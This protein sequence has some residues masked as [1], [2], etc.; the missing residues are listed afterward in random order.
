KDV[1]GAFFW[2]VTTLAYVRHVRMSSLPG[3]KFQI[4]NFKSWGWYSLA[5][6]CFILGLMSKP[7]LVPLPF[8]LLLLDYWPLQRLRMT[9]A[10]GP[11][12]SARI[13]RL[14]SLLLEKVPFFLAAVSVAVLAVLTQNAARAVSEGVPL[15]ARAGNALVSCC[16]Y[17]G[18]LFYPAH[19]ACFYPHPGYW[20]ASAVVLSGIVLAAVLVMA[21]ANRR[22]H[23]WLLTGWLWFL[24]TLAPAAGWVQV[25]E[26]SMADRFTYIP[27]LGLIWIL[28]WGVRQVSLRWH[29]PKP[30]LAVAAVAA[31]AACAVC[32]RRQIGCWKDSE[33]LFQHALAVTADNHVARFCLGVAYDE[34]GRPDDAI[35]QY[36]TAITLK[37]DYPAAHINL[38]FALANTG[39]F[40]AAMAELRE[41]LQ[42]NGDPALAHFGIGLILGREGQLPESAAQFRQA[43]EFRADWPAAHYNLG[44]ALKRAGN[45]TA[46]IPE[47]SRAVEL[48]PDS[49][50]YRFSLGSAL[51][52]ADRQDD[53]IAQFQKSL[54]LR[55]DSLECQVNLA[56]ALARSGR[57]DEAVD[58]FH[59]A[60]SLNPRVPEVHNNLGMALKKQRRFD[61][62]AGEFQQALKLKPGYAEAQNNL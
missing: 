23:P 30:A 32:T 16:R 17:P 22:E 61:E 11:K 46:A 29:C 44:I 34:Q 56:N 43:L 48:E 42:L 57:L 58:Q 62:A 54:R 5:L 52:A 33:T 12:G 31:I 13:P 25:G 2:L 51:A 19:L 39:Q 4:S 40:A 9:D 7:T 37:P 10:P 3:F 28:V 20:P 35:A 41:A 15:G 6:G 21:V 45:V 49:S 53:A 36:R 24:L 60:L 1:L 50:E 27:S 38:G 18:K 14:S 55:P 26:Q 47:L 59:A 8:A